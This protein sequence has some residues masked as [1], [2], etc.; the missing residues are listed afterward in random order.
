MLPAV[1]RRAAT[2]PGG[3][4][5]PNPGGI[6]WLIESA[7]ALASVGK[8]AEYI[9]P[10]AVSESDLEWLDRHLPDRVSEPLISQL[11][12][13]AVPTSV[14][15][16]TKRV[17][18]G[19][20]V[21]YVLMLRTGLPTRFRYAAFKQRMLGFDRAVA[22][23]VGPELGALIGYHG[24][25]TAAFERAGKLG[26]PK[27]LDYPIAHWHEI[28]TLLAEEAEL[29]PAYAHTLQQ[30]EPW[31]LERFKREIEMADAFIQ[32][33]TYSQRTFE[34]QGID[35]ARMFI[36]P[37]YADPE[38]FTAPPRAP[39]GTFKIAFCGQITQRKGISY[40]VE[41]L[42]RAG[43]EDAELLMIGPPFGSPEPWIS[44]PQVRHVPPMARHL[45]PDVLRE[46]HAVLMP[47][48]IEGFGAAALEGMAC[49]L[50]AIVS[51]NTFAEDVIEEGVDGWVIPIRDPDAI[52]KHLRT[53]YDDRELRDTMGAAARRKAEQFP[54]SRYREALLAGLQPLL[55]GR[56][57]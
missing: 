32:L 54:P 57:R 4:I 20:E 33:S 56:E 30:Y 40:A 6:T 44:E 50:P 38:V 48:L 7:I 41:G 28:E 8:L 52:A 17:R 12:R 37:L 11:R 39:E 34:E 24:A 3:V 47:S 13:R 49:G 21:A 23:R 55:A 1:A 22:K 46:C 9:A 14:G 42:K 15:P 27:V 29:V 18:V 2:S 16:H 26:V 51:T 35:P 25:T 53:L 10:T 43:L 36:A 31:R 5:V 45:L 19:V